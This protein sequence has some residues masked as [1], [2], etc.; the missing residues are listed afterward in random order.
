MVDELLSWL[1]ALAVAL[2]AALIIR[3]FVFRIIVVRGTSMRDTLRDG[4][5]L[6]VSILSARFGYR[7]GDVV[8]CRYPGRSDLCVKR[9]AALP[10]DAIRV[11]RGRAIVNGEP[12]EEPY[13][14][15][16][17]MY[18]YPERVLQKGE[19]FLLGDNRAFSHDSHSRDVGPVTDIVGVA[20]V[21]IWPLS[22]AGGIKR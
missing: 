11:E 21:I 7:R 16:G 14:T 3:L 13:V 19:Y 12:A 15:H 6:Y 1:K 18:D 8:I 17:A 20:R 5:R 2:P 9:I 4:D 10:G 22:R